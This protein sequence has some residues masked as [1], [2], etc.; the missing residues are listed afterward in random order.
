[1]TFCPRIAISPTSPW[2]RPR[3][4]RRRP[5]ASRTPSIGVP[6]EPALRRPV[7]VVER[8]HR[9]GLGQPVALE[10]VQPNVFSKSPQH[11]HG[12]RRAAGDAQPQARQSS[13]A[14]S[15]ATLSSAGIHRRHALE[16]GDPVALD[17]PRAPCA[18]RTAGISVSVAPTSTGRVE[19]AG[20]AE[21][22]EQ[23]QAAHHHVVR[24]EL[25]AACAAVTSALLARPP[26]V[27]SAPLGFPVVPE[28]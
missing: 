14:A 17:R 24:A 18:R 3:R 12:Q 15:S 19:P 26:W 25:A 2:R 20:Q 1:M 13:S 27:S 7:R 11:L 9:R 16:D 8:R 22:V 4:R 28:V 10:D 23:R 5:P 21:D 6:I